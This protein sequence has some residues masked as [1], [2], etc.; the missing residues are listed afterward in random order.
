MVWG[1]SFVNGADGVEMEVGR[2]DT[3]V[4]LEELRRHQPKLLAA[5]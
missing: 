2:I 4:A 5:A 3:E 1:E